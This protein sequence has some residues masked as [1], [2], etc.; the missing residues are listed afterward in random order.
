M[1]KNTAGSN[2]LKGLDDIKR[3]LIALLLKMGASSQ[4]I[5]VALGV[6]SSAVRKMFA[7][8]KIKK[9]EISTQH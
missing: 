2:E 4:E 8:K 5:G 6:D 9:F 7:V 1:K 3:L